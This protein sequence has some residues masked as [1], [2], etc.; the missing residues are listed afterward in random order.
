MG[1]PKC[2]TNIAKVAPVQVFCKTSTSKTRLAIFGGPSS[3][4]LWEKSMD[5]GGKWWLMYDNI[6]SNGA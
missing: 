2:H 5:S 6:H 4:A 3:Y 1:H